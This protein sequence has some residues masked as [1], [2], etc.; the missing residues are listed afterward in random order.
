MEVGTEIYWFETA[1][2]QSWRLPLISVDFSGEE[3]L[4]SVNTS[5]T[6]TNGQALVNPSLPFIAAPESMF[7]RLKTTWQA[8]N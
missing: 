8:Q 4:T 5:N 3:I 2:N 7:E 6:N 1:N